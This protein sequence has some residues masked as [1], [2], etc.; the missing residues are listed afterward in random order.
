[1]G[2]PGPEARVRVLNASPDVPGLDVYID[3]S[4]VATTVSYGQLTDYVSVTAGERTITLYREGDHRQPLAE[5]TMMLRKRTEHTVAA[6]GRAGELEALVIND[7]TSPAAP[8]RARIRMINLAPGVPAI[9]LYIKGGP[10]IFRN[11]GYKEMTG[12]AEVSAGTVDLEFIPS[13]GQTPIMTIG[14]YHMTPG[15]KYILVVLGPAMRPAEFRVLPVRGW[16]GTRGQ[17]G[18]LK[19]A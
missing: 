9:D 10:D 19:A 4:P 1:M 16:V 5:L 13:G 11:L 18:Q 3:G 17:G 14:D 2:G 12:F 15:G 8:G 6:V 7:Y